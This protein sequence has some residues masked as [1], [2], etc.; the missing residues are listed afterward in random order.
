[1]IVVVWKAAAGARAS[2][3]G[4]WLSARRPRL[5]VEYTLPNSAGSVA[6]V[7]TEGMGPLHCQRTPPDTGLLNTDSAAEGMQL[8][9]RFFETRQRRRKI[10]R[11]A[12]ARAC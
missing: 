1:M 6:V 5:I 4:D 7:E 11:A 12:T 9:R 10:G 2:D 3:V 8:A